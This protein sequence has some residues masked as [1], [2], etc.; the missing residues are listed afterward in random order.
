MNSVGP[1]IRASN[2][3][4]SGSKMFMFS[5]VPSFRGIQACKLK[6]WWTLGWGLNQTHI[7]PIG[8][9]ML[10]VLH[11]IDTSRENYLYLDSKNLSYGCNSGICPHARIATISIDYLVQ[12]K[13]SPS[14]NPRKQK[15]L[16]S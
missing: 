15:A 11:M 8:A 12:E 4:V 7:S 5:E 10:H 9:S 16:E 6:G 13:R 2:N 3:S 1:L 14:P